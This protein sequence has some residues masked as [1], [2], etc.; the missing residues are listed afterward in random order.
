M[1]RTSP[2]VQSAFAEIET[3][4]SVVSS[5][6]LADAALPELQSEWISAID[7]GWIENVGR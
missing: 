3:H 1:D 5:T 4:P 2:E 7:A 6:E